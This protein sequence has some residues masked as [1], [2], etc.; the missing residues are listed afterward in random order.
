MRGAGS[1]PSSGMAIFIDRGLAQRLERAEGAASAGFAEARQRF[2][3][4][5]HATWRDFDGT[6]AVYDGPTSPMTQTFGLG[7]FSPAT[8]GGLDAIERFFGERGA[9]TQHEVSPI[10]GVEV[11]ALL[12]GRGYRPLELSTVLVRTLDGA[13]DGL[14]A[15]GLRVRVCGEEDL[16]RWVATATAGWAETPAAAREMEGI[17]RAATLNPRAVSFLVEHEGEVIA[18]ASLAIHDG[19]ALL[20]GASTLPARRGLG[21]HGLLLAA[22][23]DEARRRGCELA[24]MVAAPA[25]TSQHNAERRGFRIAYTRSKWLRPAPAPRR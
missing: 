5:V 9:A 18:T 4:G 12:V 15:P 16:G 23:L 8:P 1:V 21:A 20:A 2:E 11:L 22:R 6:Y 13:L 24:M 3:P 25:S 19:I 7:M 14:P 17:A 10:A